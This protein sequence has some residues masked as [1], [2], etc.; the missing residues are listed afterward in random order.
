MQANKL[1][2]QGV[3]MLSNGGNDCR[4]TDDDIARFLGEISEL[5]LEESRAQYTQ[6]ATD[7]TMVC[8]YFG[9][10]YRHYQR[11]FVLCEVVAVLG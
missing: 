11:Y 4:L 7:E 2:T 10:S 5:R 1:C 3:D 8:Y 9:F 6:F